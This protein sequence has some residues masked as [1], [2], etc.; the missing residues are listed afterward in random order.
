MARLAGLGGWGHFDG[1]GGVR[2]PVVGTTTDG[3]DRSGRAGRPEVAVVA[4]LRGK[5]RR[6]WVLDARWVGEIRAHAVELGGARAQGEG[7]GDGQTMKGGGGD[8][9]RPVAKLEREG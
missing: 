5:G 1:Q 6:G 4:A 7:V 8:G 2:E 3:G 9:R